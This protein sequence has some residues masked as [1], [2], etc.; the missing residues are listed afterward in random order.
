MEPVL[1]QRSVGQ[2][3]QTVVIGQPMDT[4]FAGLALAHVAEE[5]DIADQL[6]LVIPY[7]RDTE[8]ARLRGTIAVFDPEL[9]LPTAALA[10]LADDEAHPIALL[11]ISAEDRRELAQHLVLA[12]A[13][14]AA[15]RR[16]DLNDPPLWIS[17]RIAAVECS[18]T[19]AARRSS[20]SAWR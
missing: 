16:I 8:P 6:I 5:T 11:N 20:F 19:V 15:E 2:L 12:V 18:N 4:V 14:D 13:G 3:G 9:T 17:H 7:S 1:K 10:D